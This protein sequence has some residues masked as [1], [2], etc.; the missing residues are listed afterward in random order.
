LGDPVNYIGFPSDVWAGIDY[1][2]AE[3]IYSLQRDID[4]PAWHRIISYVESSPYFQ[5]VAYID[6]EYPPQLKSIYQPPL[7]LTAIG[8]I[9]LLQSTDIIS[10]V[11]T[12]KPTQYGKYVTEKIVYSLV[13]NNYMTCSGLA[14]GIDSVT[15]R[16]TIEANGL[17]IAVTAGGLDIVYPP[18]NLE[19]ANKIKERG[20]II[21]ESMPCIPFE[22]Y[23][24]PQRNRIIAGLA[25]AVCIIEGKL[26]SG[27]MITAK[28]ALEQNKEIYALPGDI[29]RPEAQGPNTLIQRGAKIILTPNDIAADFN[30]DYVPNKVSK[31]IS[32]T[33]EE[34]KIYNIIKNNSQDI[35][36]DQLVVETGGSLGKISEVLFMLE[37][38]NAVRQTENGKYSAN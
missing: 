32:L 11:G 2:N 13:A 25:K 21:S 23:H 31:R 10:I 27:A 19:L 26:Q 24:F 5:F 3:V 7:F 34:T 36:I 4:P 8:D 15:H 38:K 12:R 22:K 28:F 14:L 33:D 20:L 37:L 6:D 9:S 17:T 35:H 1:L 16:K 18:Q 30:I 29:L